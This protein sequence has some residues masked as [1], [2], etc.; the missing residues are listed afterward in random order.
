MR[1]GSKSEDASLRRIHV[2]I[3]SS[4]LN[5]GNV[6]DEAADERR[7]STSSLAKSSVTRNVVPAGL[8][9]RE[10]AGLLQ[11]LLQEQIG[12]V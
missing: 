9:R 11:D 5:V 6:F 12:S 10:K 8:F 2:G 4:Y 1:R 3:I 7:Q